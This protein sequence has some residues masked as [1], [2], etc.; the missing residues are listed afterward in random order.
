MSEDYDWPPGLDEPATPLVSVSKARE[1]P[2]ASPLLPVPAPPAAERYH[3]PL[4]IVLLGQNG[5]GKSSLALLLAGQSDRSLSLDSETS[6]GKCLQTA[7]KLAIINEYIIH[8]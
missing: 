4:R 7:N 1:G 2:P 3:G 6:C 5:V 8:K